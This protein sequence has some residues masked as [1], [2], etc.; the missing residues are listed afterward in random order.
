MSRG[1]WKPG[2]E[3][4]EGKGAR[5]I[6]RGNYILAK[7]RKEGGMNEGTE[8]RRKIKGW[9]SLDD[10]TGGG[11]TWLLIEG[12]RTKRMGNV[13]SKLKTKGGSGCRHI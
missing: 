11:S 12:K 6:G 8:R 9:T 3:G 13:N 7:N 4:R 2:Q 10:P 1:A 5:G